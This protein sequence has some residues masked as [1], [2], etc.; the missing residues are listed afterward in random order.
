MRDSDYL[1]ACAFVRILESRMLGRA[2]YETLLGAASH[3]DALRY[4]SDKGRGSAGEDLTETW[5]EVK[6]ACPEDAPLDILLYQNDFH[7]LKAILKAL[8][9]GADYM[10]LMLEPY[11]IAP[12]IIHRAAAEGK[13]EGLPA[14]LRQ[15]AVEAYEILARDGD[16]QAAEILLDQ[17]LF[18]VIAET[19]KQS[20]NAFLI[21]WADLN[22]RLINTKTA[23]RG[24]PQSAML[25]DRRTMAGAPKDSI[26]ALELWC[27]NQL[28]Q[29]L[30]I[31]RQKLFGFE[32]VFAFLAG[33]Q[34]EWQALR[35]ILS[36]LRRG[37]P[38]GA[39]RE[40]LRD[41]YV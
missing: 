6:A 3:E 28:I 35:I 23:L 16:G 27:D 25:G 24:G 8:F 21:Q 34:F 31:N 10:P 29:Y 2:D 22:I 19:A 41:L 9:S 32:P 40:R 17:A 20:K 37:I 7:N 30:K 13:L 38:A 18:A 33:R 11:T 39:L 36:G 4:L 15:P 5:N 12:D 26:T 1:Y 14:L